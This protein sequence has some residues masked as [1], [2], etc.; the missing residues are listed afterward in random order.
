MR[1]N[2]G[3]KE[4]EVEVKKSTVVCYKCKTPGVIKSTYSTRK[5]KH[6]SENREGILPEN[7]LGFFQVAAVFKKTS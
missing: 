6:A 7:F 2:E 1:K 3:N 5:V 4:K